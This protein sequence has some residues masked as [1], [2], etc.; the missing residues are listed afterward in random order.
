MKLRALRLH[1]V[2]RFAGRGVAIENI[3]DGVNVLCAANEF[4][5]STCF[6]ALHALF[7]LPHGST[8]QAVTALRPYS[9]GNPLIEADIVTG[10]GRLRIAK[11][12]FGGRRASVTDLD[13]GRLLAQADEAERILAELVHGGMGGPAGLLWVRQGITGI[14]P[15]AKG[16][17][18]GEKRA[19]E[20]VLSSV[21]GEV[22][23]LT[24]GRRMADVQ[25]A[26]EEDLARYV[27]ATGR[28]KAGGPLAEARKECERLQ[29]VEQRLARD[30]RDLQDALDAR[31]RAR[32]R[33]A[34]L[35]DADED[36]ARRRALDEAEQALAA[37]RS[38]G[39]ALQR[40]E[41][42]A[43]IAQGR[44][45]RARTALEGFREILSHL[46]VTRVRQAE[47]LRRRD[48]ALERQLQ[49]FAEVET[50]ARQVE[51]AEQA[52]SMAREALSRL[53]RGEHARE[54]AR[55]LALVTST[56]EQADEAHKTLEILE[57][58]RRD[59]EMPDGRIEA[60]ERIETEI[61]GLRAAETAQ[62]PV[63]RIDYEPDA[64]AVTLDGSALADG[65]EH[66][67]AGPAVLTL[68]GIGRLSVT[69][70]HRSAAEAL[71]P[72]LERRQ[73]ILAALGVENLAGAR[74]RQI[75][76]QALQSEAELARQRLILLAPQGLGAMRGEAER[77]GTEV[78]SFPDDAP[79]GDLPAARLSFAAATRAVTESRN[80]RR[81]LQPARDAADAALVAAEKALAALSAERE[82][83]D[84]RLGPEADRAEREAGLVREVSQCSVANS[85]SG[86]AVAVLRASAPDP[87]AAEA[88]L[89]RRR[90]ALAAAVAETGRL[91][92]QL[93]DLNGRI[94]TRSTDAVEEDW[95]EAA[96]A[97]S[98]AQATLA[99]LER[100]VAVLTRLRDTLAAAR[101]AAR[102]HYFE[103]VMRELR[104]LL[105]SMFDDATVAFDDDTLLPR[106]VQRNGQVEE[107]E[108]LSG[109]MR[110]QLAVL[111][112]LAFARLLAK[113]GRPAPVILDDALVYSD[114]DRIEKMFDALHR[115]SRE[116]QIIVFSC[117]QRAFARLGGTALT[118][119]DWTPG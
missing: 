14:E 35:E 54:A 77:L 79:A 45:E 58:K 20:S 29:D 61:V 7:F 43:S 119:T 117:R 75:E 91:R 4:G 36:A 8:K 83:L 28:D 21:R 13:T 46:G 32:A 88:S 66:P 16:D 34:E 9:G 27:T 51:E 97:L 47:A 118:L 15:R 49:V 112:R 116:Q 104:P 5:K 63:L 93:A 71:G 80:A 24:G 90:S 107:V 33:L 65:E 110:E 17:E 42:A 52:E 69:P 67:V 114:D 73:G 23:A 76:A 115:Q 39:E 48:Q 68:P 60:L 99:R 92:E 18:E 100:E 11:Q 87:E 95:R 30:V 25:A 50:T 101:T 19:R 38:H 84:L 102:E 113:D 106:T 78:A 96:E 44:F 111:T 59:R 31:R 26:C 94:H 53:E 98:Q 108:R 6:D 70:R 3:G 109:G 103:P 62:A 72:A 56:L 74:R 57:E 12:F 22:E 105:Q 37:A 2:R 10:R 1:N 41:T 89:A 40:A 86:Q 64:P 82:G 81:T 55:R 85:E